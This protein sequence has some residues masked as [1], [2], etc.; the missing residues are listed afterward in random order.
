[1]KLKSRKR[2]HVDFLYGMINDLHHEIFDIALSV[3]RKEIS[4]EEL[5]TKIALYKKYSRRLKI[6]EL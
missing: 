2:K 5:K 3:V 6:L 1:M 4:K